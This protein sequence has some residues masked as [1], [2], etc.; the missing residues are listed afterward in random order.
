MSRRYTKYTSELLAPLVAKN[1]SMAG[2][3]RDL[4]IRPG[5]VQSHLTRVIA[6]FGLD[7]SHFT[8]Q[9]YGAGH[10]HKGG[11][12]KKVWQEVLVLDHTKTKRETAGRLRR[13]LI[14]SGRVYQCEKC[15]QDPVWDNQELRL[16]VDHK[17]GDYLDNRPD[18][19][20]FLCP[21][22]HSQTPGYAGSKGGTSIL[23]EAQQARNRRQRQKS[24]NGVMVAATGSE[25]VTP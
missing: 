25:P 7:T 5:G 19:V 15:H 21:N 6:R 10:A 11:S 16:Q 18:N 2:V 1:V 13:A 9:A 20:R 24:R 22:C 14:D 4:G 23:S 12:E 3:L 17:N 8:G